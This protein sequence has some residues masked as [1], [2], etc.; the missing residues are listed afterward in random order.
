MTAPVPPGAN[1]PG[2]ASLK[3]A[4]GY[5]ASPSYGRDVVGS[6]GS[7]LDQEPAL[8]IATLI[9][10]RSSGARGLERETIQRLKS[11]FGVDLI[12]A[13]DLAARKET[14]DE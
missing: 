6:H 14:N 13:V 10:A 8:L 7:E 9:A 11:E 1:S 2:T 4:V 12:F 3:M 5:D